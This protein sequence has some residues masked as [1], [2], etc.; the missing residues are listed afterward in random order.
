[1]HREIDVGERDCTSVRER[2][3]ERN[4]LDTDSR[5]RIER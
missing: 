2:A 3:R 1:M 4:G 5:S